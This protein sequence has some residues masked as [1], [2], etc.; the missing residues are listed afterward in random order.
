MIEFKTERI[1]A[2]ISSTGISAKRLTVT[3]WGSYPAKLDLRIWRTD[4]EP[5]K[6]SKGITLDREEAEALAAALNKYLAES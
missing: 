6:P 2:E 1:I 4:E 3:K 5:P